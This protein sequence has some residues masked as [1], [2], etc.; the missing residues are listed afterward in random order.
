MSNFRIYK[1]SSRI[2]VKIEGLSIFVSPLS[3]HHKME[4]QDLMVKAADGDMDSAMKAIVKALKVSVKDIQGVRTLN[5]SG[6]DVPYV[7][8]FQGDEV[9]DD[10]INDLLNMPISNKITA[11]CTSL[12][13]GVSDKIMG[14]DGK[15]L[16]GVSIVAP[17]MESKSRKK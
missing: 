12:L 1:T 6:E 5:E 10:C 14:P 2:E 11:V 17:K 9:S 13:G 3:Y 7:L 15:P 8:E 4:L 16:E